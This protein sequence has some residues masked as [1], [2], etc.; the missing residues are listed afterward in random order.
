MH[1]NEPKLYGWCARQ[2]REYKKTGHGILSPERIDLLRDID[3]VFDAWDEKFC[4]LKAYID[5]HGNALV[6]AKF[7]QNP[8]L[9]KWVSAQRH[10]YNKNKLSTLKIKKLDDVGFAWKAR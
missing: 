7:P 2:K 1:L 10:K 6:P 8:G 5:Q 4:E 9:G 3:F